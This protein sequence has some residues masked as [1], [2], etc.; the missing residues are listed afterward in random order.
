MLQN[1][2]V[3]MSNTFQITNWDEQSYLEFED[4]VKYSK[5]SIKKQYQGQLL[6]EGQLEYLM[7]YHNNGHATFVGMEHVT[8]VIDG[9]QGSFTL[10]HKGSFKEGIAS[11]TF[12]ILP[13][14]ATGDLKGLTGRGSFST[15]H[16]MTVEFDFQFEL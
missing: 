4:G 1:T 10:Q 14:S 15:G 13:E 3:N 12:E 8:V 6:G 9:K 2:E 5:A 16:S 7:S 11:S